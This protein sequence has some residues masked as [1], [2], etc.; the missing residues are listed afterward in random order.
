MV[1]KKNFSVVREVWLGLGLSLFALFFL[2]QC[3][4]LNQRA[5]QY[6]RIML[7]ILLILS[8]AL[9]VQGIYYS[10]QPGRYHNRYGKSNKSIQW[11][12]VIHPLFVFGTTLVYLALFH[13]INCF[14]AT[15]LFVPLLMWIFGERSVLPILLTTV[16][17]ELFVYLVFVQLLHVYFPM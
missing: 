6:P 2:W 13:Y 8:A 12:V 7:T 9:L 1:L 16:G 4:N 5:A 3:N 14:V 15:A 10:F 11:K 17:L